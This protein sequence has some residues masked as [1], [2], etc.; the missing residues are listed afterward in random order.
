M[1]ST[2]TKIEEN[3]FFEVKMCESMI[4]KSQL[5]SNKQ[6]DQLSSFPNFSEISTEIEV[7]RFFRISY[8]PN[9]FL[10]TVDHFLSLNE[11]LQKL[12][13]HAQCL[14]VILFPDW[15]SIYLEGFK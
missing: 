10:M 14:A 12:N 6:K 11:N 4:G 1:I 3:P 5:F 2:E 15:E 13:Y 9:I 8:I 7:L